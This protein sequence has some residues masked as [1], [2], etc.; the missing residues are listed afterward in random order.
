MYKA[1]QDYLTRELG[2]IKEA[3]LFKNERIIESPQSEEIELN[4][5]Q[6][7]LNFCANNYLCL[8][9]SQELIDAAKSA[10]DTHG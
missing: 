7:V 3:G 8:S 6:K 2:D 10:L 9:N 5:G 4:T 1:F